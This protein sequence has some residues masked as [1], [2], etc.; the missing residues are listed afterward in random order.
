[1]DNLK[2][3]VY[4]K[5]KPEP[6]QNLEEKKFNAMDIANAIS[7]LVSSHHKKSK[8]KKEEE[9]LVKAVSKKGLQDED[10]EEEVEEN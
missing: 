3:K 5:E 10:P 6:Q 8:K 1:M 7:D 9:E 4:S 2:K